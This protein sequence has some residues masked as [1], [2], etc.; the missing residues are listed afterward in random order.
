MVGPIF[1]WF[2]AQNG[3]WSS[4][5]AKTKTFGTWGRIKPISSVHDFVFRLY[6]SH[7]RIAKITIRNVKNVTF[8]N[9]DE[10]SKRKDFK[11]VIMIKYIIFDPMCTLVVLYLTQVY[12]IHFS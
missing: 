6:F 7:Q 4:S 8:K 11:I 10:N 2:D 1:L 5:P 9:T 3:L 12:A